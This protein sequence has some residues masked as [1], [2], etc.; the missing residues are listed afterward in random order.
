M[1]YKII[2]INKFTFCFMKVLPFGAHRCH[3]GTAERQSVRMSKITNDVGVKGLIIL[4]GAD[5]SVVAQV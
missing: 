4:R 1:N 2:L 5:V 3:M